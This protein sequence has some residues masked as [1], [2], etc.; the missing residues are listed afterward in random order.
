[1][2]QPSEKEI[3]RRVKIAIGILFKNDCYLLESGVHERTISHKLAEYLQIQFPD[4]NVDCEYNK[5]GIDTK[6]QDHKL[7]YPDIIVHHRDTNENLLIIEIKSNRKYCKKDI[8]K[9]KKFIS[10]QY[11]FNYNVGLFIQFNRRKE[12]EIQSYSELNE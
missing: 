10:P 4:W 12:P 8:E 5:K 3:I 6:R 9:I 2:Y 7:V 11:D 1:M